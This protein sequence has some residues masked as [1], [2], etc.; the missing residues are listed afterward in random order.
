[1]KR[2]SRFVGQFVQR[3]PRW[4]IA[5][6]FCFTVVAVFGITRV[7]TETGLQTFISPNSPAFQNNLRYEEQFGSEPVIVF[8]TGD[9]KDIF[10]TKNLG[11][12]QRFEHEMLSR[13]LVQAIWGPATFLEI[14]AER[15][16]AQLEHLEAALATAQEEAAQK[17]KEDAAA[18]GLPPEAQEAA[19]EQAHAEV[20]RQY[21]PLIGPLREMGTP[22]LDNPR[23]VA[24][25]L[26]TPDGSLS[27]R[28]A[29]VAPDEHH[30]LM[31]V[32][33]RGNITVEEGLEATA[34]M[35]AFFVAHPL[36]ATEVLVSSDAELFDSMSSSIRSDLSLLLG[37]SVAAM[38]V[39]LFLIFRVRWRLLPL[40]MVL[41]GV[42]WT[43]GI[44]GWLSIP[45]TMAT[46]AVLPILIGL[47]ID[48]SIQFHNRYEEETVETES[49][50]TAI[51]SSI[52]HISPAVA[53]AV[54]VTAI[55][56]ITLLVSRVP[57][58]KDFGLLLTIGVFLC[59]LGG[60]F[61][62]NG[63]LYHRDRKAP[64]AEL[65]RVAEQARR[66]IEAAL[67]WI[68]RGVVSKP[69]LI[70]VLA[71]ALAATGGVV[72]RWLTVETDFEE[73]APQDEPT[74]VEIREI[75]EIVGSTATHY[76]MVEAEDVTDPAVLAW[77]K[78][79]EEKE[80]SL[81]PELL[82]ASS[83][84]DLVIEAAGGE[85]PTGDA[86]EGVLNSIP[87]V[88][89]DRVVSDDRRMASMAFGLEHIS[90]A[91]MGALVDAMEEELDA[92]QGVTVSSAGLV[93]L[94]SKTLTAVLGTRGLMTFLG[95]GMI[96]L[97]LVSIYRRLSR[98]L[99][100]VLP[101][102]LV[103]GWS[104]AAM[105]FGNIALNPLT[106]VLSALIIGIGTEYTVLIMERYRE[107]SERGQSPRQAMVV[108][109][110]KVGRAIISSGLTTMGG[111]GMLIASD[112]VMIKDF[113][114][115]TLIDIFLC[116]VAALVVLPP[117]VVWFDERKARK[118][119]G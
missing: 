28:S 98:A 58:V 50:A 111:F 19:A 103:I 39:I 87:S 65:K 41:V 82:S 69:L 112:F 99:L 81:H 37:L 109:V 47:G 21:E 93:A 46:M 3:H 23:F 117:L 27:P 2:L 67:A 66:R 24:S 30:A 9:V 106:A 6:A 22:S 84:A 63:I 20:W 83:P 32:T 114:M 94:G 44:M 36:A 71:V 5:A 42:V 107:E 16:R 55:S 48:Y 31:A 25:V 76:L 110:T 10:S 57:M 35:E 73:L 85:F 92:P 119:S 113:G 59:Y 56:F 70:M 53:V 118:A 116:L 91:E 12:L 8:M 101:V 13:P 26:Y 100:V 88:L 17:A 104:S 49:A 90:V 115:V 38:V 33:L 51:V 95:M 108:A 79:Y 34:D 62:L 74:L 11:I 60:L 86:M 102:L 80:L 7:Y 72:D 75:R 43:F 15:A 61:L 4:L 68:A 29:G 89:L 54:L 40:S 52:T 77:M 105:Y 18:L 14:A 97:A 78:E 1:M 45:L 96:F 64:P